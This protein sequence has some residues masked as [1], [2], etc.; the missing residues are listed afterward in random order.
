[1]W[2]MHDNSRWDTVDAQTQTGAL[3]C[4][5]AE[6]RLM[7]WWVRLK[8]H[9]ASPGLTPPRDDS[10]SSQSRLAPFSSAEPPSDS[11]TAARSR[12]LHDSCSYH[13]ITAAG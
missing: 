10:P 3:T 6:G 12:H 13:T 8:T 5:V 2:G 7:G 9:R 1:M 11:W 4:H